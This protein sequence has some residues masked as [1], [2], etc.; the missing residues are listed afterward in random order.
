MKKK[1]RRLQEALAESEVDDT[2]KRRLF[3]YSDEKCENCE[4]S[5]KIKVAKKLSKLYGG[6][7]K[8]PEDDKQKG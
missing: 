1:L 5:D 6:S 4:N 8:L 7:I 2:I 3:A